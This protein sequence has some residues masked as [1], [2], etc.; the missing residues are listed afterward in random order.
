MKFLNK[1]VI[2][3]DGINLIKSIHTTFIYL[4]VYYKPGPSIYLIDRL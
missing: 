1:I 2:T 4:D 3:D